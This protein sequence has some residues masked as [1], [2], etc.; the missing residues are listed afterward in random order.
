MRGQSVLKV[1]VRAITLL[2][3]TEAELLP[4]VLRVGYFH[5]VFVL[6]PPPFD[7]SH[8]DSVN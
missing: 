4:R 2:N 5:G 6:S 1:V 3:E 8:P 7:P